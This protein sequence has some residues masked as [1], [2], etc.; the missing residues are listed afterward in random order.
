[1]AVVI[2]MRPTPAPTTLTLDDLRA[3]Y[4]HPSITQGDR[5]YA[6]W[7]GNRYVELTIDGHKRT[8]VNCRP[9]EPIV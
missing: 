9:P 6:W 5:M 4:G 8:L 7:I 1:M 2:T 3:L